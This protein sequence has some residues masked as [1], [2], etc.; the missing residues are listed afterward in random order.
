MALP[1]FHSLFYHSCCEGGGEI[2]VEFSMLVLR[3]CVA[4][5]GQSVAAV[6]DALACPHPT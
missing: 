1:L 6:A 4:V 3:L 2:G 5:A